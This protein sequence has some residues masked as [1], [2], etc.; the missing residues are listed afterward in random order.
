MVLNSPDDSACMQ[1]IRNY[2]LL[3]KESLLFLTNSKVNRNMATSAG[4]DLE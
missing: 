3:S 2:V 4:E 1:E